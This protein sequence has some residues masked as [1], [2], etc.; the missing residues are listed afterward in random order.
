MSIYHTKELAGFARVPLAPGETKTVT[1][2]LYA[3]Q[4]A[5]LTADMHWKVEKG[6]INLM[7]GKSCDDIVCE[8]KVRIENDAWIDGAVR[9]FY[10]DTVIG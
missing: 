7:I 10:A 3:S 2:T 6:E 5:F 9:R 4:L 1:F 8:Q